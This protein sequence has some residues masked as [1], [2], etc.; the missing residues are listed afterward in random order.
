M[1]DLQSEDSVTKQE[2]IDITKESLKK[3]LG[4]TPNW[5]SPDPDLVQGFWL[6]NFN[7]LC[8]RVRSKL[9]ECLD[10]GFVPSWLTKRRTALLQKDK[11]KCYI[12]S[13]CRPVTYL[14]LMW[15]LLGIGYNCRSDLMNI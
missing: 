5:K 12:A 11:S 1:K 7:S 15:K 10:S 13:N 6:K 9:K 4:K 8:G 3:I 2:K 14:L